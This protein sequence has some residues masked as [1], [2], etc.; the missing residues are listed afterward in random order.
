[1]TIHI[2][3]RVR[4][5]ARGFGAEGERWLSNLPDHVDAL[6]RHWSLRDIETMDVEGHTSWIGACTTDDGSGGVL[7]VIVPHDESR[8][9][10]DGLRAYDG[11]GAVR[12]LRV[13]ED[14]FS[15]LLER[16]VPGGSLW[17]LPTDEGNAVLAGLL[18]RLWHPV[19]EDAPFRRLTDV[20]RDWCERMP[21][22]A[23]AQGYDPRI[24]NDASALGRELLADKTDEVL[25]HGDLHPGNV[26]AATREPWLVI[27]PKPVVGDPAF[28]LAQLLINRCWEAGSAAEIRRQVRRLAEATRL[29]PERLGAWAVVKAV[30]W[31]CGPETASLLEGSLAGFIV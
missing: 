8:R 16:C 29:D 4:D 21:R 30:G 3:A 18:R 19:L 20:V 25:L 10:A 6:R 1:M 26:L 2:P 12:V 9:E 17:G 22:E 11:E 24:A 15:L 5:V 14:G 31:K 27:D 28:D 23:P 7:K 13:T